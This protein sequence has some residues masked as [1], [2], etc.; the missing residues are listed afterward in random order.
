LVT[1]LWC[2]TAAAVALATIALLAAWRSAAQAARLSEAYWHLRYE[3]GQLA[4]RLERVEA[5]LT[6]RPADD[7]L[8]AAP[9]A[10]ASFVPLSSLKR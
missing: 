4:S 5:Q 6:G 2:V 7:P 8:G 9:P 10:P 3:Q 1:I